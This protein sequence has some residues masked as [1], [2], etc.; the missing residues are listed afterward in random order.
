MSVFHFIYEL[1]SIIIRPSIEAYHVE[2]IS[3]WLRRAS[4]GWVALIALVVFVL[5]TALVLPRQAA[6]AERSAAEAGTPDLSFY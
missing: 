5:F 3:D 4:S 6:S 1:P 2:K